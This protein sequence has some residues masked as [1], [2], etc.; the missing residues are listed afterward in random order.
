ME[1][2]YSIVKSET[3][4]KFTEAELDATATGTA[5]IIDDGEFS[6]MAIIPMKDKTY[7]Q[8]WLS[9]NALKKAVMGMVIELSEANLL[10]K[11]AKIVYN[12]DT[13]D[14]SKEEIELDF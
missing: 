12:D 2:N 14:K 11:T 5:L 10:I 9:D 1:K 3:I 7:R 8:M 6:T 13:P 4:R